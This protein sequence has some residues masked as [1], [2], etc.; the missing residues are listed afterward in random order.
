MR[1]MLA[2]TAAALMACGPDYEE[3]GVEAA[4]QPLLTEPM[5]GAPQPRE[6]PKAKLEG[7]VRPE[8][9][10]ADPAFQTFEQAYAYTVCSLGYCR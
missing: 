6:T 1:T 7:V 2:V 10:T 3:E 9:V 4:A 5:G 8:E